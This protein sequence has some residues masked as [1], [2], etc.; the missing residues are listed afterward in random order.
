[1]STYLQPTTLGEALQAL[2]AAAERPILLAGGT[3]WMVERQLRKLAPVPPVLDISRLAELKAVEPQADG[4]IRFGSLTTYR[5]LMT[6]ERF[7]PWPM[8]AEM[9]ALVGAWQIQTRGT[10]GGNVATGSPAGDS[11]PV[12]MAYGAEV[13][14][15]SA[16]GRRRV[17]F[18]SFYTG[19]RQT[20]ARPDEMI[21]A[22]WLPPAAET[23]TTLYR[24]VGTRR[25]QSISKVAFAG[26]RHG[27]TVRLG[28][29]SVG[30][31]VMPLTHTRQALLKGDDP[32]PALRR[33]ITPID[34][35]RSTGT[36]RQFVAENL[37]KAFAE[38]VLV[39]V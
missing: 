29:A 8:L 10:I 3:D 13:E 2:A 21:T 9:A 19:Y 18:D 4:G 28:M 1:M 20:V 37:V 38:Q 22:I 32:I 36:Y 31:T 15:G 12:L 14:L 6:D 11:L 30:P 34:D 35:V 27:E 26:Y 24:K 39:G 25:A 17:A 5:Q 7:K 33:D 16:E 23:A